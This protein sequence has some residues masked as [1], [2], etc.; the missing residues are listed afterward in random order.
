MTV[1]DNN[2]HS[3]MGSGVVPNPF[4]IMMNLLQ[5]LEDFKTQEL[6]PELQVQIPEHRQHE[7][8]A[9]SEIL[10]SI[11][12]SLPKLATTHNLACKH[13]D[14]EKYQLLIK[15]FWKPTLSVIG[16]DG[17]PSCEKA[18]NVLYKELKCKVSIRMP[19]TLDG[20]KA[21]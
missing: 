10:P 15:N 16:F 18:G 11:D 1:A 7:L 20:E 19:P 17:L 6:I 12:S 2:I 8:K 5:R 14:S 9:T 3:G 21:T 13:G 4:E